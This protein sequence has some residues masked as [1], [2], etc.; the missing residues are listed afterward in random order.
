MTGVAHSPAWRYAISL[1]AFALALAPAVT[2]SAARGS[3]LAASNLADL[4]LEQLGSI[5]VT[6]VSRREERLGSAAASV[7]VISAEDI[8]RSGATSIPEALRLAPNLFVGRAD[9]NQ[10]AISARGFSNVLAN[11]LLVLIDG[12]IVYS[13]L[14]SGVFWEAQD[15][16]LEDVERIEV[17]SGPGAT[18]WG[19]NAVN[20]VINVITRNARDTQGALLTAGGGNRERGGGARYGGAI[21]GGH[22]RVYGKHF[23]RNATERANRTSVVD[24]SARGQAGFRA[25][26][27]D[28][29]RAVTVQGDV[30]RGD[31]EQLAGGSRDI[32]GAN[33]LARWSEQRAD[34]STRWVQAYYDRVERDQRGSIREVLDIF[35]VEFQHGFSPAKG[36][37]LL[38]GA[39]YRHAHDQIDNINPA[40]LAFIPATRNLQW[41][42]VF[43]QDEWRLRPDL[44]LTLGV[45]A[46]HNDY[47]G[48]EWLPSARLA[49]TI[50]QSRLL[51]S[52]ASRAVR[53]PSRIDTELFTP[54][55]AGGLNFRS[56][57]SNVLELGYRAQESAAFSYSITAF[58]HDHARLRS[59]EA[60]PGGAVF[61]NRIEGSTKGIEAWS[62]WRVAAPWRLDAGWVELRQNLRPEAGSVSTPVA[63]GHGND[64]RR[65]VTLRSALELTPR[66][67]LDLSARYVGALPNPVV[68]SY[69]T[70]DVRL[71]WHVSRELELSLLLQDL[72]DTSHAEWGSAATRMELR[73]AAFL[74]LLWRPQ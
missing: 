37:Q 51:W 3:T 4:S 44:A 40:A 72:F 60:R 63:A 52:A 24:S 16:M 43:A 23:D 35:D 18:L 65:W 58:Y 34:G 69:T 30:Y 64:P 38:W 1:V 57:V 56:E 66:H 42:N 45:K 26:W 20:G 70:V 15:V 31:I 5:V 28:A 8:R 17:I 61:E 6:S 2:P 12:R 62:T 25:D 68:P 39:G 13:P 71:G 74:K 11:R 22:F 54:A 9:A 10:Y 47:T 27:G 36:H 53:A 59:L 49:Y 50:S 33:V 29:A 41:Y 55:L 67:E 14:F 46:E 32:A 7:Y 19:A 48:L 73:R 21:G